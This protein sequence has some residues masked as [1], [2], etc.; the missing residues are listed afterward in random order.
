MRRLGYTRYG[1]QGGD[2]GSVVSP[3]LGRF[4][5]EHGGG[6]HSNG[7]AAFTPLE[8]AERDG[9]TA[10]ERARLAAAEAHARDG[11]AYAVLQATRPQTL[12]YGLTDSQA[13]QLAWI[14]EKFK[15]WTDPARALPED[16]VDRDLLLANV[17]LYWLTGTAGSSAQLYDEAGHSGSWGATEKSAAPTGVAVFPGDASIRRTVE[18]E[19]TVV[20]WSEFDRG[21]HFAAMEAPDLLVGDI[22]AFFRRFR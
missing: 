13:G 5:P 7:L 16:A 12:A 19:H 3:A 10:A 6:V 14:V 11:T 15:E 21:G 4:D 9:L 22:R 20:H 18:R 17:S 1:A 2:T 8:P